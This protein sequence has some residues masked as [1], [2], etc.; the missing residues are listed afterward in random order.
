[1]RSFPSY[2]GQRNWPGWW[3]S[4]T[5]GALVGCESR[6]EC[7]HAMAQDFDSDSC[8]ALESLGD[9]CPTTRCTERPRGLDQAFR[10][11]SAAVLEGNCAYL[12]PL[13]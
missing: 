10:R 6:L 4:A 7:D 1:M 5:S 13:P 11:H 9:I 12:G 8:E 3:C 2:R